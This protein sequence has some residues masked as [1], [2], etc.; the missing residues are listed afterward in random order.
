[1]LEVCCQI[2]VSGYKRKFNFVFLHL[3]VRDP[4]RC[5]GENITRL[6]HCAMPGDKSARR[7]TPGRDLFL[8][9]DVCCELKQGQT[10]GVGAGSGCW[11]GGVSSLYRHPDLSLYCA[12][13][14]CSSRNTDLQQVFRQTGLFLFCLFLSWWQTFSSAVRC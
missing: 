3:I 10:A 9:W 1:M 8:S 14:V 4:D 2:R 11:P 6:D 5:Q 12:A 13:F 7:G